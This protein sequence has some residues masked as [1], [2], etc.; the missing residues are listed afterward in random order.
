MRQVTAFVP[1]EETKCFFLGCN[2][3][4][5]SILF[6]HEMAQVFALFVCLHG[7]SDDS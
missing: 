3:P 7:A 5:P 6:L 2:R 1:A 4:G